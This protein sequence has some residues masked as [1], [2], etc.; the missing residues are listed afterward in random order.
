MKYKVGEMVRLL[1]GFDSEFCGKIGQIVDING[2]YH[3]VDVPVD[4]GVYNLELYRNE[5][6]KLNTFDED[7]FKI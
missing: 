6:E 5:F 7:L 1:H 3:L 4:N 2:E